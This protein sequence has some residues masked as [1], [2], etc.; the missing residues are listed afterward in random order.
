MGAT[1]AKWGPVKPSF[2][3]IWHAN[4][5]SLRDKGYSVR[6]N[7]DGQWQVRFVPGTQLAREMNHAKIPFDTA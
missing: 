5:D 7:E 4:K 2:W 1:H 3:P 6:K